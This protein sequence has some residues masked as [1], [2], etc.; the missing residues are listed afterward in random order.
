M[1]GP[2]DLVVEITICLLFEIIREHL[3]EVPIAFT[4]EPMV[5]RWGAN[6]EFALFRYGK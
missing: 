1:D 5:R 6:T 4:E 3:R 2:L